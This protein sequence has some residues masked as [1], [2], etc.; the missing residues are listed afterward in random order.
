MNNLFLTSFYIL[1]PTK[2]P[3]MLWDSVTTKWAQQ[4]EWQC[5]ERMDKGDEK[6]RLVKKGTVIE[7]VKSIFSPFR[8]WE[9]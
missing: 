9:A 6:Q 3:K 7:S 5:N 4:A 2:L 1:K 8:A